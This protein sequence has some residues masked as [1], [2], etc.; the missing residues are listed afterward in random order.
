MKSFTIKKYLLPIII[1]GC[2]LCNPLTLF[3]QQRTVYGKVRTAENISLQNV[4]V[5]FK[6]SNLGTVTDKSGEFQINIPNDGVLIFSL[7]GFKD[8]EISTQNKKNI[9]VILEEADN[10]IDEVVVFGYS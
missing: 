3:A 1:V 2:V 9:N 10:N 6:G 5:L 4:T 7:V 8:Q